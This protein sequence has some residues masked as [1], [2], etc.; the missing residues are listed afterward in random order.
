[1]KEP[2]KFASVLNIGMAIVTSLYIALGTIGFVTFGQNI[3]GS[4]T[5]NLPEVCTLKYVFMSSRYSN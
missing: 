4:I 1:M 3:C 5:L 2:E